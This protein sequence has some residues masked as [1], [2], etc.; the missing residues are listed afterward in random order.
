MLVAKAHT[1]WAHM[2]APAPPPPPFLCHTNDTRMGVRLV[3]SRSSRP[4]VNAAA[5]ACGTPATGA[6]L[7]TAPQVASG[8]K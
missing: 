4:L 7:A 8:R 3:P 2:G 1:G 5:D 6:Q